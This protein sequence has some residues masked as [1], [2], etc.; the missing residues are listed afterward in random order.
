MKLTD[1][2]IVYFLGIGGIGMSAL[3]RWFQH[4]G[5][6]IAGY[7]RTRTPLTK[8]LEG[9]GMDIHYEDN[10]DLMPALLQAEGSEEE[11]LIIYTPAIPKDHRELNF[12]KAKGYTLYKRSEV[13]GE[14]TRNFK[15]IAVAGTHGKTT[16]SSMV[17][18]ILKA[19]GVN[20]AA[21]LGG[22]ATNYNSNL[23]LEEKGKGEAWVVVEADEFDRSFLTLHPDIAVITA[24]EPDHLD[25]YGDKGGI[26]KSFLDFAK[27]THAGG[28]LFLQERFVDLIPPKEIAAQQLLYGLDSGYA[29]AKNIHI[30]EHAFIFDLQIGEKT[31]KNCKLTVP[32]YHN[33]EN[34]I[35]AAAVADTLGVTP[36]QIR[37]AI[38]T[39][40][41]VKRRFEYQLKTPRI[42]YIDDYAHHPTEI[43]SFL[44]SVRA[45]YPQQKI[46]AIFQP[47]LYSRTRD[48]AQ[49][50]SESLGLADEVVLLDIYPA[51]EEPIPG[52]D[53]GMLLDAIPVHNK[54]LVADEALVDWLGRKED[55]EVVATI[56]AGDIDQLVQPI[57]EHLM[58]K[59]HV[60]EA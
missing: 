16:T 48:F 13:L 2:H 1:K 55:L 15:T 23:L 58:A 6:S 34:A 18:H 4:Q 27:Q 56:G 52:V 42:T 33:V 21:F 10:P 50:F 17:A 31:I 38:A 30:A 37:D 57:K 49:G 3:A 44:K 43:T 40:K 29:K 60:E 26:E 32:G 25:I 54:Q 41:G 8:Q 39:Y 59:Y 11:V 14:I 51:R 20:V 47:H 46:T 35:A 7:D 12:L 24:V 22:I 53:S 9:E 19:S 45:L 5:V 28:T 36:D